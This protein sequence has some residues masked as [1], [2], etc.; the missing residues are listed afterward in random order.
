M[1]NQKRGKEVVAIVKLKSRTEGHK[2]NISDD[3]QALKSIVENAKQH[4]AYSGMD[5]K[6]NRKKPISVLRKAGEIVNLN[7]TVG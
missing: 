2:A 3:Y 4:E 6:R 7:M 1:I 5:Q